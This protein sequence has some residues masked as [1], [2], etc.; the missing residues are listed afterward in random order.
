LSVKMSSEEA[1]RLQRYGWVWRHR[2]KFRLPPP[3]TERGLF[4]LSYP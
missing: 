1:K 3:Q 4:E 2:A